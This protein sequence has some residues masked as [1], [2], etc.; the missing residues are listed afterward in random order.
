MGK[1]MVSI[2][3]IFLNA[4]KYLSEAVESIFAQT[5]DRW[6][7]LLVDDGSTDASTEIAKRYATQ[8]LKKVRYLEHPGHQNRGKGASRNLGIFHAQGDYIA[9]LDADDVWLPE[10]LAQQTVI[11]DS[12]P[13]AGMLYG[14]TLYW[15]SWTQMPEDHKR[16]FLRPLG[17]QP[18]TVFKP[19]RLF[20]LFL[21]GMATVPCICSILVRRSAIQKIGGFDETF[22]EVNDIH[23]DQTLYAKMYLKFPVYVSGTCL[24][25]YRQ[26]PGSSMAIARNMGYLVPAREFFLRWLREYLI[27]QG[28]KDLE[29]WQS[30]QRELW[31]T[32]YPS[33]LPSSERLIHSM[34]W[35][36]KWL[37]RLEERTL[38]SSIQNWLWKQ[39]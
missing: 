28:E 22:T 33:W 30:L 25:R 12:H 5:Y 18:N 15:Y 36:K 10:K 16:D 32:R 39:N 14:S 34:M 23:E 11:L 37:L 9:F 2:I 27:E 17:V 20:S 3:I 1:P 13:E 19:P 4:E 26:H 38:P 31:R 7:I 29:V 8:N 6:E 24:D 21:R 35:A